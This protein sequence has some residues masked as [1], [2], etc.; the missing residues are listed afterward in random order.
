MFNFTEDCII[1]IENI[2]KEHEYLFKLLN[3]GF[4]LLQNE[5]I[6]DKYKQIIQLIK[7]L[8]NYA[9]T[10]FEHEE[11]YMESIN[12]PEL[13]MQQRQHMEFI[14]QIDAFGFSNIDG[15]QS[16]VLN[17]ILTYMT[18]WLYNHI[19]GSDMMIGKMTPIEEWKETENPCEFTSK[20][21]TGIELI[22]DE[23]RK[24][25][26]IIGEANNLI[27]N[28][29]IPDKYDNITDIIAKLTEYT[30]FHFSDEEQYM[31]K[32]NYEGLAAQKRAHTAFISKLETIELEDYNENQHEILIE[33]MD[34]LFNW[35]INHILKMDKQIPVNP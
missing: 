23:H 12:D 25:F 18:R 28:N 26:E 1:G 8:E 31:E 20:Y 30:K 6:E 27:N 14:Q 35:L 19:I 24:L 3:D 17:D 22:D 29:F 34:F 21:Y 16:G 2:D 9:D 33:L 4:D 11:A 5:F 32:I 13:K 15:N 10:H 7:D